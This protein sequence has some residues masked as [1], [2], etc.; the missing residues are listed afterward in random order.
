MALAEISVSLFIN[1]SSLQ[2]CFIFSIWVDIRLSIAFFALEQ[3]LLCFLLKC[4]ICISNFFLHGFPWFFSSFSLMVFIIL[5]CRWLIITPRKAL[6]PIFQLRNLRK[7]S[8]LRSRKYSLSKTWFSCAVDLDDLSK[9][10]SFLWSLVFW[11]TIES[12]DFLLL[13]SILNWKRRLLSTLE[14]L[15]REVTC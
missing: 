2:L 1:F 6:L 11:Y 4:W 3:K 13:Y 15:I 12:A 9:S 10:P 8:L 14:S 7:R 5:N